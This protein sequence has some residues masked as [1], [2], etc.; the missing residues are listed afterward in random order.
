MNKQLRELLIKAKVLQI[1]ADLFAVLGVFLF[2]YIYFNNYS[3]NALAAIKDPFF[4]VTILIPFLPAAVL[5]FQASR[6]RRQIRDAV[7]QKE[8][9]S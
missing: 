7:E 5:A 8:K 1:C 2:A 4:I 3:E 9:T 6:L